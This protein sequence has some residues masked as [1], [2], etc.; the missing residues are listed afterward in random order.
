VPTVEPTPSPAPIVSPTATPDTH[1]PSEPLGPDE[2]PGTVIVEGAQTDVRVCKKV[3]T[4]AGRAVERVTK[5]AGE[6]VRFRIRVTNL[7]T[8]AARNVVVCDLLPKELTIVRA[9]VPIVYRRGRPCAA[10][11]VLSGQR[12]GFIT[13][14][15]ARTA[16]GVI[17]NVAAV[18]SRN[19]GTRHNAASIRVLPARGTGGGVTG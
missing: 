9:T 13:V 17:T 16:S 14:R 6:T 11:P 10:I 18:T 15:I 12:Q 7:G 19:G 8:G 3:M 4:P 1:E 5:H 2:D